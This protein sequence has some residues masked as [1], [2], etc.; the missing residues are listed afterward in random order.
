MIQHDGAPTF[1]FRPGP[2]HGE[3]ARGVERAAGGRR[4]ATARGEQQE[5]D[6]R[7]A[8]G[9]RRG[10][11]RFLRGP[12]RRRR[13]RSREKRVL[14]GGGGARRPA[15]AGAPRAARR[16]GEVPVRHVRAPGQGGGEDG[17]RRLR[18]G[19]K[20]PLVRVRRRPRRRGARARVLGRVRR[21]RG[22][23]RPVRRRLGGRP[24]R[25]VAALFGA[26]DRRVGRARGERARRREFE[27]TDDGDAA[28]GAG[29][30][31]RGPARRRR[32][33]GERLQLD[34]DELYERG[35]TAAIRPRAQGAGVP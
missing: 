16:Q 22:R 28:R 35:E 19:A 21:G 11:P 1:D 12:G 29:S 23:R 34:H 26:L 15:P 7:G 10:A 9:A 17:P 32:P 31:P 8:R 30:D 25:A 6:R 20:A 4:Q 13:R 33:R 27:R 2:R 5:S 14:Q 24:S 18:Q 3:D